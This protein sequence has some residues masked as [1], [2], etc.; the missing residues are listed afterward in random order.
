MFFFL[1]RTTKYP[2]WLAP[3]NTSCNDCRH[4]RRSRPAGRTDTSTRRVPWR[5]APLWIY[6][7]GTTIH[8]H[9]RN[10]QDYE[11]YWYRRPLRGRPFRRWCSVLP[12][13]L[14]RYCWSGLA[15]VELCKLI[16]ESNTSVAIEVQKTLWFC[17]TLL[18]VEQNTRSISIITDHP[19]T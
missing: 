3:S 1:Q 5:K 10:E 15:A 14:P 12:Q 19:I 18:V 11:Q 9:P 4:Q 6:T 13:V 16:V 7:A 17:S 8:F 2:L